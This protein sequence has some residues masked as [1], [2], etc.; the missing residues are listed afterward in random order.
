MISLTL[1][2]HPDK[3]AD[4]RFTIENG[5]QTWEDAS[6]ATW[7][8]EVLLHAMGFQVTE[9]RGIV[10]TVEMV[11]EM[12]DYEN[13]NTSFILRALGWDEDAL[14]GLWAEHGT[15]T[16]EAAARAHADRIERFCPQCGEA[17]I[18]LGG[19]YNPTA[20]AASPTERFT[21]GA[22]LC[23]VCGYDRASATTP[24]GDPA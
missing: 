21:V 24:N 7:E 20:E 2:S 23:P 11:N 5:P 14:E 16:D 12:M 6:V 9:S 1:H 8:R 22:G 18:A 19:N 15:R 10:T 17:S 13:A 4:T 3:G